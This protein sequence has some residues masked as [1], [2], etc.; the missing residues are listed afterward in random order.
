[1]S[2][3][4]DARIN[5]LYPAIR[6]LAYRVLEDIYRATGFRMKVTEGLRSMAQQLKIY[7]IGRELRD[8]VWVITD[9]G[10]IVTN[11]RPGFSWHCY[12]LACDFAWAGIDPYLQ[13]VDSKTRAELWANFGEAG[14]RNGF[15]WGGDF[16]LI[17]GVNDLPHLEL[18][19]GLKLEQAMELYDQGSVK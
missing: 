16:H 1:M 3:I 12:G 11:A 10:K 14:K 7:S 13:S 4:S 15:K 9:R 17:N 18:K 5:T 19:F 8:G 2:D 6:P